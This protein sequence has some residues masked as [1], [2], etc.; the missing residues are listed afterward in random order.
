MAR[1]GSGTYDLPAGNPVAT[2]TVIS[3]VVQNNTMTDIGTALTGSVAR[4]GQSP[5]TANIPMG[6]NK[7]TGLATPTARTDATSLGSIQDGV[8]VYGATVGGS[9]NA[10]TVTLAPVITA[11][12]AGQKFSF[13]AGAANTG[14]V[15]INFNALGAKAITKVGTTA[16]V[17]NDILSSSLV[18]VEYDGTRFQLISPIGADPS[19]TYLPL[20][21]GTLTGDLNMSAKAIN[22]ATHTEAAHA[23]TS[24]I[25][26]GGNTCLLSGSVV[27]FTDVADAPAV[28]AVRYVVANAAHVIT[29]NS[30]LEVDGNANYTCAAGDLLRFEAKTTSTFRVSVVAHGDGAGSGDA[31]TANPL[32]QFAATTSAQLAGVISNETGSGLLVFGTSPTLVTPAL[33]TPSALVGTNISGTAASLTAGTVT[34]NANLTGHITSTGNAAVLGSFTSAQLATAL[35]NETGSGA[36]CF[37]TAPTIVG[38][39]ATGDITMSGKAVN[40]AVHT[41]A[42]HAT[43]SDIWTGGN[44][45]LLSGSVVTFTDVADAPQAGAVRFV[46]ANAAHV[47]TDN[48]AL[49]VDGNANYTCG[50]GDVLMFTA[51]TTST[52]RVNIL[53]HGD[54]TG[55]YVPSAVA[56]TGGTINGT[57]IGAS[58]PAAG[59]FTTLDATGVAT[60]TTFEPDGDTSASDNAAI[61]YTAAEGLVLTGQGSSGDVTI[62]NDADA[63]VMEVLTGTTTAAFAGQVTGTGFTGTLDGILG[64]GTPAAATTTTLACTTLNTSGAVVFN[65]AGADVDFRVEGDTNANLL[66]V[67]ASADAVG[68]G[69]DAPETYLHVFK[70]SSG[71][72]TDGSA[73]AHFE[74]SGSTVLQISAGTSSDCHIAFGDS[75]NQNIGSIAYLNNGNHMAFRADNGEKMRIT[76]AGN[77]GIGIAA[78]TSELQITAATPEVNIHDGAAD[79]F[80]SGDVSSS[81]LFTARNS[82]VRTIGEIDAIHA[83]TN[84]TVGH[85]RFQTRHGDALAERMRIDSS[86]NVGIGT[87][88]PEAKLDIRSDIDESSTYTGQ[89]AINSVTKSTGNLARIM[90]SHD[91]HGSASIASDYE[92]SGNGNLIFSTRGGGNP[93]ERMRIAANGKVGIGTTAPLA[94]NHTFGAGTAVVAS[95]SDGAAEAIIEGANIAMTSSYGNLNVISNTAQ[96]ANTGGQIAF[97]GKS[98]DSSNV[99]ATWGVIKGGKE[100]GTSANIASYLAFSTRA[101]GGGNT[102]KMRISSAGKLLIGTTSEYSAPKVGIGYVGGTDN[103]IVLFSSTTAAASQISFFVDNTTHVG[104]ITTNGSSS[105]A[106]N[107]SSDYRL[108]ENVEYDWDATTRL[109][110]LKPARFNFLADPDNT[111]DGFMAHEA[112]EVVPEAV[113]GTKD[114]VDDDGNIVIQGIDQSKLVPL[115]VKTIQELEARIAVLEAK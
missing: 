109:K 8:G 73:V 16:L 110:Q 12:A 63:K 23:T 55:D 101:N 51:K 27:T 25:W 19:G 115:L 42:A 45:C 79:T 69:T 48:S 18:E 92:S 94:K 75:G 53:S 93:T 81:L 114:E 76:G 44:T 113:T 89:L 59:D 66:V 65:D 91:N 41:E 88:A 37:A 3:S 96:A 85:L 1:N 4:D 28:G 87:T 61:G 5:A 17:A 38:L 83:S 72:S 77:V 107:T 21:G 9:G 36:A 95:G 24:D 6:D 62:K 13:I 54:T 60:A 64:S 47:I 2:G 78:P 57:T 10:I 98:T 67:D 26:T 29:D 52:F 49:E 30:S 74:S 39:T 33:G 82:S 56:I 34:T 102:E 46:V 71:A 22:E 100:N 105:T 111:V 84:G 104:N 20:A 58:T 90:F 86:G 112:Q 31:K 14:G 68:I 99:Y 7:L 35:T 11:Y 103:G 97:G 106:Y 15:T 108:K 80:T 40:E 70:A 50:I 32:S 43:T